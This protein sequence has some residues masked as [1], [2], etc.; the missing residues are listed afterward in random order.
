LVL[1]FN[2]YPRGLLDDEEQMARMAQ[3][4]QPQPDPTSPA[5]QAQ[6]PPVMPPY[7]SQQP[8]FQPP[9]PSMGTMRER[10]PSPF[11]TSGLARFADALTGN[12]L[13]GAYNIGT[14]V[15]HAV[16]D[17]HPDIKGLAADLA[18]EYGIDAAMFAASLAMPGPIGKAAKDLLA[19]PKGK[20]RDELA[21]AFLQAAK[22]HYGGDVTRMPE[23]A[24]GSRGLTQ[25]ELPKLYENIG[26]LG[27]APSP[28][29]AGAIRSQPKKVVAE[30]TKGKLADIEFTRGMTQEQRT[31][32]F[33][34]GQLPSQ[35]MAEERFGVRKKELARETA[36][37]EKSLAKSGDVQ[38]FDLSEKT[39]NVVP[40]TSQFALPRLAPQATERMQPGIAGGAGRLQGSAEAGQPYWGWYNQE[41]WRKTMHDVLGPERGDE[42]FRK[43]WNPAIAGTS[44]TNP[45]PSNIRAGSYY[46]GRAIKGE[47]LPQ[48]IRVMDPESGRPKFA[49]TPV[50]P[51]VGAKAQVQ[52]AARVRQ[53]MANQ[54]DPVSNPKPLSYLQNL[55]GNWEPTTVD[56]HEIRNFLGI[57][58]G[59]DPFK[60]PGYANR[61]TPSDLLPGEYTLAEDAGAEV[62]RRMGITPAQRQAGTW[63]GYGETTGLK[64]PPAPLLDVLQHRIN[65]TAQI[66]GQHPEQV[67]TDF[68]LNGTPFH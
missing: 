34:K 47:P 61:P 45:L 64:S 19:A 53:F 62:A 58:G 32:A 13:S 11:E 43:I 16:H 57:L 1:N 2:L 6:L 18:A 27:E 5:A 68:L 20:A 41:Q 50:P 52:H 8:Q 28:L 39:L 44:M 3:M 7:L 35:I 56:T 55:Q 15:G 65:V 37:A 17:I 36:K 10:I 60:R 12:M 59:K 33:D 67:I 40:S 23:V 49:V 9:A 25:K 51:G 4:Q 29:Q 30:T 21:Q 63:I 38:L 24:Q 26:L 46:A 22:E 42:V 54:G 14:G 66:R 48:P 31:E